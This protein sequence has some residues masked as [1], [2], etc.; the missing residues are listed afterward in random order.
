MSAALMG[1]HARMATGVEE[2]KFCGEKRE[3]LGRKEGISG[4][5][6][7]A[8]RTCPPRGEDPEHLLTPSCVYLPT[9]DRC[10]R[11]R[12]LEGLL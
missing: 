7:R 2:G 6:T 5:T 1:N 3:F 11:G 9:S 8:Q 12:G 10:Q 4:M